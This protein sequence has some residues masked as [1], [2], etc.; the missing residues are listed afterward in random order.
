MTELKVI[1]TT[2]LWSKR[3]VFSITEDRAGH[4]IFSPG[5]GRRWFPWQRLFRL[6]LAGLPLRPRQSPAPHVFCILSWF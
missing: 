2:S 1:V 6:H 5:L 3:P 4:P